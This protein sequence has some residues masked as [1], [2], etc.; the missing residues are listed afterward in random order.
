[1]EE[2]IIHTPET[3]NPINE[4]DFIIPEPP[5]EEMTLNDG[6]IALSELSLAI[7]DYVMPKTAT[8]SSTSAINGTGTSKIFDAM[9][10]VRKFLEEKTNEV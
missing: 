1:M 7:A 9:K 3:I 4:L 2:K 10:D 8:I 5:R 6:L